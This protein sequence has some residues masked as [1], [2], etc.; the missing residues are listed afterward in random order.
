MSK[1]TYISPYN[2]LLNHLSP[3]RRAEGAAIPAFRKVQDAIMD[4]LM[5]AAGSVNMRE[6]WARVDF[7]TTEHTV[8]TGHG[9]N[10]R[11]E[12]IPAFHVQACHHGW[13]LRRKG[14]KSARKSPDM[15]TTHRVL[16]GLADHEA[17]PL[18][19]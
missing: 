16:V 13:L 18:A 4:R 9:R 17:L 6:P 15:L 7:D 12:T 8:V 10:K 3:L 2:G 1:S 14:E 19:R 5:F 11:R